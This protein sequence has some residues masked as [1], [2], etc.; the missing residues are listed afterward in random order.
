MVIIFQIQKFLS[1]NISLYI[2]LKNNLHV[3]V[4]DGNFLQKSDM[5]FP[6][7]NCNEY[8]YVM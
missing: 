1:S 7:K 2:L 4:S 6:L 5:F 8:E 3:K